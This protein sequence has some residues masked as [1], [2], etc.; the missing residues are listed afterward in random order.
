MTGKF[1]WLLVVAPELLTPLDGLDCTEGDKVLLPF[2]EAAA[3]AVVVAVGVL[4]GTPLT[5]FRD[6]KK[7]MQRCDTPLLLEMS[8]WLKGE[9]E[10]AR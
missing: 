1:L 4:D 8:R 2:V 7:D 5:G 3:A 6:A 9:R 10:R